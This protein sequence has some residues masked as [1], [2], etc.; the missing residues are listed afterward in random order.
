MAGASHTAH[1]EGTR[2]KTLGTAEGM[3]QDE[4]FTCFH[5]FSHYLQ[6]ISSLDLIQLNVYQMDNVPTACTLLGVISLSPY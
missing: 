4:A 2:T 1:L 6:P 3:A 5:A